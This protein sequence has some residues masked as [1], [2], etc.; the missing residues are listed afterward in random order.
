MTNTNK[1]LAQRYN[2]LFKSECTEAELK[3]FINQYVVSIGVCSLDWL[4]SYS[5]IFLDGS[6]WGFS[7]SFEYDTELDNFG[8]NTIVTYRTTYC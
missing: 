2:A 3:A 8:H 1:T 7:D 5:M 4:V 6:V